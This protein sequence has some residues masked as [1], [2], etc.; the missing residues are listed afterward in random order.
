[1]L[2]HHLRGLLHA[3]AQR[4]ADG[5]PGDQLADLDLH[6]LAGLALRL[7]HLQ[8]RLALGLDKVGEGVIGLAQLLEQQA[9]NEVDQT[10]FNR[11]CRQAH[12]VAA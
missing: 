7:F 6:Q 8:A 2:G 11:P 3:G 1:M 5:A 10:V 12:L 9:G 4:H